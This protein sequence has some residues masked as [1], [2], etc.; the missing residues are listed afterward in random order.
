[1]NGNHMKDMQVA[2]CITRKITEM[3]KNNQ[4]YEYVCEKEWFLK[5]N[6][7]SQ[8]PRLSHTTRWI[9]KTLLVSPVSNAALLDSIKKRLFLKSIP[10]QSITE[11]QH[12]ILILQFEKICN[13]LKSE[14]HQINILNYAAK[15]QE[16][17]KP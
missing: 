14:K 4:F 3:N 16:T 6:Y 1:M 11:Q 9:R 15:Y 8:D 17:F 10:C 5:S 7:A 13:H 12:R 2:K